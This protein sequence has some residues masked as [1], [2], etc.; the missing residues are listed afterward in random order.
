MINKALAKRERVAPSVITLDDRYAPMLEITDIRNEE[1]CIGAVL[2]K[3]ELYVTLSEIVQP[4][5]FFFLKN[6]YIWKAFDEL[7][8]AR[9]GIDLV[10][11]PDAMQALNAPIQ[12]EDL[13][14]DLARMI[15]SRCCAPDR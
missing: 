15:G 7:S 3:P 2:Q 12:G 13:I 9:Q 1:A 6:G 5:D 4:S 8:N 11:V 10:T 14:R